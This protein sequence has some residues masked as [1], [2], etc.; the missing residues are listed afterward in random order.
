MFPIESYRISPNLFGVDRW[1]AE[2]TGQRSRRAYRR[3]AAER[4]IAHD[5]NAIYETGVTFMQGVFLPLTMPLRRWHDRICQAAER[6][7][8]A[9]KSPVRGNGGAE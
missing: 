2:I 9:H 4:K 7:R 3:A 1:Q 8:R 6:R 5:E